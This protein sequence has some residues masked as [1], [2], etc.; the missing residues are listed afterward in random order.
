M[1]GNAT[2]NML[3]V[4]V[5]AD[6]S[7]KRRLEKVEHKLYQNYIIAQGM[8]SMT[9]QALKFPNRKAAEQHGS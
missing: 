9:P 3:C 2:Q 6:E 5:D 1:F 8:D 4:V 7:T